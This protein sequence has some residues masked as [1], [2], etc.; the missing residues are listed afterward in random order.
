[1]NK[2][3]RVGMLSYGMSGKVF[4]APL[5]HVNPRYKM[6]KI[7]Q[8]SASDALDR[9]PY[10]QIVQQAEDIFHDPEIDLVLVNTPDHTHVEYTRAALEAG[11]HVVVEKPFVHEIHEG[12]GLID[13]AASKGSVLTVFQSRRWEGDFLTIQQIINSGCLGRLVEYE[14]HFDRFRNFIRDSWKEK[15]EYKASTLYNLGSH[16]I[17]QAL[18]LFGIPEAVYA[19]IRKQ[20]T[21]S[22]VDDLFELILYYP[23]L[24]VTLKSSY[25]VRE[26]GPRYLLHG[27]EGSYVKYGIDPQ[28]EA[29]TNGHFPDGPNWGKED[30]ANWGILNTD[31]KGL[32]FR[33]PVETLPGCYP[34]FYNTLYETLVNGK[35]LAV[36]PQESLNGI[37]IIRAAY[38][39]SASR[40]AILIK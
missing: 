40:C 25:L 28:E 3:I 7:M 21:N 18:F 29:L 19:D 34:E 2:T 22:L 12:Q 32:H 13:L 26:E 4:H 38:E 16:L 11:K 39:S 6:V 5:L 1:M 20:R 17:D 35:E 9:Y 23:G 33:G 8:R 15:P 37:K 27:T 30:K 31:I 36:K 10:V 24:K 14:A